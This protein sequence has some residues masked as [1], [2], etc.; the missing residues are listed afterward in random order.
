M[1]SSWMESPEHRAIILTADL[2]RVGF[3]V[4]TGTFKGQ[5]AVSLATADFSS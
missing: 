1:V 3:G 4:A 5:N 2:R